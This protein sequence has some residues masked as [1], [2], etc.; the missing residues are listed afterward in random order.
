[1]AAP[2]VLE[3]SIVLRK[4]GSEVLVQ[5]REFIREADIRIVSFD[6]EHLAA[7]EDAYRR[8]G[9][10]TGHKARLNFGDCFAYAACAISGRPLLFKGENFAHTDITSALVGK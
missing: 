8:F 9:R 6:A 5:L 7:A 10:G 2:T 4:F 3:T 1:M